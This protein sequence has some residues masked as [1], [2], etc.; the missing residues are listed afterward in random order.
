MLKR[1]TIL[2]ICFLLCLCTGCSSSKTTGELNGNN[3][4]SN[5]IHKMDVN[6]KTDEEESVGQL[7]LGKSFGELPV[8]GQEDLNYCNAPQNVK[9]EYGLALVCKDPL[10]GITYFVNY[11]D[12]NYIYGEYNGVTEL[13]VKI[14]AKRLFCRK[15]KL[16]FMVDG[17]QGS[18]NDSYENGNILEYSPADGKITVIIPKVVETMFVYQEGI[19]YIVNEGDLKI[20]DGPNDYG[21]AKRIKWNYLFEQKTDTEFNDCYSTFNRWNEKFFSFVMEQVQG[22]DDRYKVAATKLVN[23]NSNLEEKLDILLMNTDFIRDD[24]L[25]VL[26]QIDSTLDMMDLVQMKETSI[27]L[28]ETAF[29]DFIICNDFLYNTHY[30]V[31]N[32]ATG[33]YSKGYLENNSQK[34]II[35]K[36]LYT[37]GEKIYGLFGKT[38]NDKLGQ[39]MQIEVIDNQ[40]NA[41]IDEENRYCFRLSSMFQ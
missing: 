37:D 9:G 35:I 17:Y 29:N 8:M 41:N 6:G 14:P 5:V 39:L 36:E 10:Y 28:P 21:L 15:G 30:G 13:V 18:K 22:Y 34:G 20:P 12:D 19:Y 38:R 23:I 11:G 4:T 7:E 16:Y 27:S 33:D 40:E 2:F 26:N 32:L 1:A 24:T 31:L 25:Y 3:Q